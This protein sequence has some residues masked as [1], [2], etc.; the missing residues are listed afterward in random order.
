VVLKILSVD[1]LHKSEIGGVLLDV[2]DAA[3]V[4]SG[5]ELLLARARAA[6]PAARI[7]GVLVAKQLSGGVECILGI[8]R[9]PVFGP[10]AVFGLGG[11]FIEVLHDVVLRRCPFGEDTAEQMVRS[12][13]G[14]P[15]L[16]GARGKPPVDIQALA[17]MLARLSQF[18]HQA[19]PRLQSIDLNPV[20]AL[21]QG[22]GAY[23]V[24][25]VIELAPQG[26]EQ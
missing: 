13:Q 2:G 17:A 5:F 9:D 14:A 1:I 19:G 4:R 16:L 21:P 24:D 10:V 8:Q 12:I 23:A 20:F 15:L 6:V 18:A 26:K 7:E 22:Q 11:I 25:A 3:A